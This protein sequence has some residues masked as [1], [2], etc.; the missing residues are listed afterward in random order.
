MGKYCELLAPL[1]P[2]LAN[3]RMQHWADLGCGSGVLTKVLSGLLPEGCSIT[4]IDNR[5]SLAPDIH[6]LAGID[7]QQGDFVADSFE[8]SPLD[9]ILM[10]NSLHFV[11][12]KAS[13]IRKW[14]EYFRAEPQWLVVEYE[15]MTPNEWEP[16]PVNYESLESL[17]LNAGYNTVQH[18]GSV[19]SRYGGMMYAA[20][21]R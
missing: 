18:L 14:E 6:G 13:L 19:P 17:F 21:I 2:V 12:D 9:G 8:L 1:S 16:Y 15:H 10:A 4:A 5:A 7:L 11:A 20:F 3:G